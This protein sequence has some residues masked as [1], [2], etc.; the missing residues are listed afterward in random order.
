M[1]NTFPTREFHRYFFS[2]LVLVTC[3]YATMLTDAAIGG[4]F[5]GPEA[6]S[7]VNLVMP[8]NELFYA[9]CLLLGGGAAIVGAQA[10]G[11]GD[12]Q[13]VRQHFTVALTSVA[14]CL[15]ALAI[16]TFA[17]RHQIAGWLAA[18]SS[19]LPFVRSYFS[20]LIPWFVVNGLLFVVKEFTVLSG[21]PALVMRCA[22]AQLLT[23]VACNVLFLGVLHR[24][25][26]T[27]A[28]SSV[29]SA[30]VMLAL[31]LPNYFRAECPFRLVRC[32]RNEYRSCLRTNMRFGSGLLSVDC[33]YLIFAF[34]MNA[35]VLRLMGE[36][37]MFVW[38]VI[39]MAFYT[40]N[41]AS[42]AGQQTC[43]ALGGRYLGM[44]QGDIAARIRNRTIAYVGAFITMVLTLCFLCPDWV[45]PLWGAS[46]SMRYA[47]L[48]PGVAMAIPFVLVN[49]LLMLSLL[50]ILQS[51]KVLRYSLLLAV[52]YLHLPVLFVVCHLLL[53]GHEW[54]CFLGMLPV[55]GV[56]YWIGKY[57]QSKIV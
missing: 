34:A 43:I 15:L 21:K 35:L 8:I 36:E 16:P 2:S 47:E 50:S 13:R 45:M 57:A 53:P 49:N 5:I 31:L 28:L 3:S 17:L 9:L 32:R 23:N 41:Y 11:R 4:Y 30:V 20:A 51:G 40:A 19:L 1:T 29:I 22:I 26:G 12:T 48:L 39:I 38:S 6:V 24:G 46:D 33:S 14:G 54:C 52:V 25:I 7:A 42:A 37:A 18:D 27:L 55:Q 56:I 44:A 10:Y